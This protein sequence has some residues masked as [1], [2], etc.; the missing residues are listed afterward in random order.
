M[1]TILW[2]LNLFVPAT[3]LLLGL[4]SKSSQKQYAAKCLLIA[5]ALTAIITVVCRLLLPASPTVFSAVAIG[6]Q[7]I[8]L[9]VVALL[10]SRHY[11]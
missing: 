9:L 7:L 1:N 11:K 8:A 5:A 4:F 2:V 3:M 6:L 10:C